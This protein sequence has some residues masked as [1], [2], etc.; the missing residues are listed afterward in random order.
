MASFIDSWIARFFVR[1]VISDSVLGEFFSYLGYR[2][3]TKDL[4]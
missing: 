1:D 2:E 3:E 4:F